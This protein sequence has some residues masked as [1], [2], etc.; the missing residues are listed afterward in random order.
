MT[1]NRSTSLSAT[2]AA[3]PLPVLAGT[4]TVAGVAWAT[5]WLHASAFPALGLS[6]A[7]EFPAVSLLTVCVAAG[8][9][10][11]AKLGIGPLAHYRGRMA[12][13]RPG[14]RS[15]PPAEVAE[16]VRSAAPYL[17]LMNQQLG[18]A[19]QHSE[20]DALI[21]IGRMN[22]IHEV[23]NEQFERIR[24]SQANGSQLAQVMHDKVM[25][26]AQ[27]GAI[28]AMF[29][30]KQEADVQANLE[31]MQRLQG[32]K[33]LAP[34]V[35][36]IALVARQTN[37]L[38]INAAIEAARAGESGRGFA[39][40]AAEIRRLSGQTTE[41]A[42]DIAAKIAVATHGI[43]KELVAATAAAGSRSTTGNMRQVMLDI[44][45]MQQRFAASTLEMQQL[46]DG[47]R[48]G[49]QDIV[50]RL[51]DALGQMQGQDVMR[52][53]VECVQQALLALNEH[54]QGL[55][56]QL[57]GEPTSGAGTGLTL[58]ERLDEQLGRYVMNS[59]RATHERVTGQAAAASAAAPLIE[60]F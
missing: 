8:L 20:Q 17:K 39:V 48:T 44:E 1:P 56:G 14:P 57:L 41:V 42:V 23:S 25:V 26:D 46:I 5:A 33:A 13:K 29:V 47:V 27:L 40:V 60:L 16:E 53:R 28:L 24:S 34:L 35:D 58:K 3:V 11:L 7:Q 6:T 50:A 49:H 31:R 21:L 36:V 4:A 59:Q 38:S 37:F 12:S 2:L 18:G 10:A 15:L 52:Q 54:L 22:S 9:T 19:L 51:A 55:A 30:D 43:D 45:A 32:V